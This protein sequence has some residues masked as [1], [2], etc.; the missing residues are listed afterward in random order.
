MFESTCTDSRGKCAWL[1]L[2]TGLGQPEPLM[3]ISFFLRNSSKSYY[4]HQNKE[5]NYKLVNL[6]SEE[7]LSTEK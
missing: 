1:K 7:S 4:V 6:Y 2:V 5:E 3:V